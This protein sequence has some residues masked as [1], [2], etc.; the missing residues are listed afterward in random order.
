MDLEIESIHDTFVV[1]TAYCERMVLVM[2]KRL[3]VILALVLLFSA[4]ALAETVIFEDYGFFIT[5]PDGWTHEETKLTE[6]YVEADVVDG[7]YAYAE[8]QSVVMWLDIYALDE[9]S[10]A[11]ADM[12][13]MEFE[14]HVT[15]LQEYDPSIS[16]FTVNGV[17]FIYYTATNDNGAYLTAYT[18]TALHQYSFVF[19]A[20]AMTEEVRA[21]VAQI[22]NTYKPL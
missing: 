15:N 16:A 21:V 1:P 11:A 9:E 19:R 4:K 2:K 14:G 17:P 6:E 8:D 22:M 5:L 18:W 20:D 3:G 13:V 12:S 7:L 10:R